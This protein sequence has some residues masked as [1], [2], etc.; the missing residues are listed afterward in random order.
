MQV[1]FG[2]WLPDQPEHNNPG[3]NVAN[4]V[5]YALN[6]YKRFPSLVNYSTNTI[7]KN[8][9][10][11][12][13]F[14]DNSNTVFNFVANEETIFELT[15]GAFTERGAR[16]KVLS[17]AFATCTITVSDYANIGA[18]KT[19][20]LK[21]NDNTSIVFTSTTGS[22]STNE[23]QVQTNNDTTATNLKNTINGHA[24]FSA[25]VSGAVVTV[26]RAVVGNVNLVNESSDTTRLTVTSFYGG[27]PLTGDATDYITF[28]QFGN[29][30]IV[31]NGVDAP[32][33]YLMGTS[34]SFT[35]LSTIGTSGTVPVFKCSGV[36][37]DFL[38]TGNHVGASNRI[39]W[40]GI[41]DITTWQ[42]GT[43]QSD[44]QDLPGSGGQITHITSGEIGYIFR[45]NQIV[46][47]DYV[48][49]ATVFRL[50]VISPNRGAV[51]GR[52]VCQD[53]RRVFFYA[54]DG[55]FEINGDQVSAIG[56]EKV[57]RFFDL[58]LNKAFADRIV[59]ATD[60]F[61]QLAI[62]LYP[63]SSDTSNTTGICDKVLI[64]NYATQK[65]STA[66]ANASTIFSQFV[67]A[68]TVELM[69]IISENLD[70]INISLDT[71]FWNGGQ[72]LLGAIDSD[73]KAAI[74]SGTENIGEIE[75]SELELFPGTRSNIIGVRPIVD[76]EATVT[77]KTRD[78]LSDNSTESSVSSMNTTGINPVRQSG[79]YV[80]FNVKIPS[81]GAWKD[82]QG[83][84][85]VASRSGLR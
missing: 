61:N 55:F 52:T 60:P 49:G 57:N 70:N 54:D 12:G 83:I 6:S 15:G 71:D 19:V 46:R 8:S 22:P 64:Y 39:Q 16:G 33:F 29:Y 85:I 41:N 58:D 20:T 68:Y 21:K 31:S 25:T 78:R 51:L 5:Y 75:T 17:T 67:G 34:S 66:N 27:T 13:S 80:K 79:R 56:A 9:R 48:G 76:A 45:Q 7:T 1:P 63:S 2:E 84:D 28:T 43:K 23:F 36:I 37:R 44:L 47:M 4:N 42:P 24:D 35:D 26:T 38:V 82:A 59:A 69:D 40:S 3:A 72:L 53:N 32:Q 74:F 62:W 50:S 18:S 73:F 14:R 77:I 81:G 65:W 10:G 30:V 11:A